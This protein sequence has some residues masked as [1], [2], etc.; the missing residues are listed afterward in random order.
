M[1]MDP[2]FVHT[3]VTNIPPDIDI[4]ATIRLALELEKKHPILEVQK[5]CGQW[6]HEHSASNTFQADWEALAY[7][8][9][10]NHL[11]AAQYLN[12]AISKEEWEDEVL[13]EVMQKRRT[14]T[15]PKTL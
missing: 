9:E 11:R 6:V 2:D 8:Q 3:A 5:H 4:E 7:D 1:A 14:S 12:K 13:N 10:P 15:T